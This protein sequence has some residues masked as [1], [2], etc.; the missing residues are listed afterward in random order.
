MVF[1]KHRSGRKGL[2]LSNVGLAAVIVVYLGTDR[3][4]SFVASYRVNE[5]EM[6]DDDKLRCFIAGEAK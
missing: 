5:A 2:P 4:R 1:E 6:I 3:L